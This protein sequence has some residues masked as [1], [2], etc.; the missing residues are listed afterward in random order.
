MYL[1][2]YPET[3]DRQKIAW[4][5]I[6]LTDTDLVW[7]LH[8]YHELQD[9]DTWANYTAAI[10]AKYWN[11]R[12]AVDTQLKLGQLRYHG[13]IHTY[14]MEFRVL[15]NFAGGTGKALRE[16]IDLAIHNA[17]LDMRFANYLEYF[18][19]DEG[20]LQAT[21]QAGLQVEKKKALK[22]GREQ[23]KSTVPSGS[24]KRDDKRKKERKKEEKR[25]KSARDTRGKDTQ[26]RDNKDIG[27]EYRG[28][29]RWPSRSAAFEGVPVSKKRGHT[30][31]WG[32]HR[33]GQN[34]HR[35]AQCYAATT[36]KGTNL[37]APPWRVSAGT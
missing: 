37:P 34:G 11:E 18:V 5:G 13:S 2:F 7:H 32:Y 8:R 17:V 22:Q 3:V 26:P 6:L 16:K 24:A 25:S 33:C 30:R 14:L 36:L 28:I 1:G 27:S 23:S 19:D 15:N 4:V 10:Q 12:E 29:E 35:A 9:N 20:F 31:T 21:Y